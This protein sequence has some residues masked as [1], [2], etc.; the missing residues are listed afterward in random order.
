MTARPL[1]PRQ[2]LPWLVMAVLLVTAF[3]FSTRGDSGPE[4]TQERVKRVASQVRCP[5]CRQLSAAESDAPAAEAVRVAIAAHVEQGESDAEIRA[6]LV[7]SYG[8]DILLTPGRSGVAALVWA[9]PVAAFVCA[10]AGLAVAFR[11]WQ[12]ADVA[13]TADDRALVA[14][15]LGEDG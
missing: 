4:T 7:D 13:P 12:R 14:R 11:R 3:S 6:F 10:L 5:T 8:K 15:A 2:L 1:R 9:L